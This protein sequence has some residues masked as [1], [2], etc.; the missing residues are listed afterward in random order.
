MNIGTLV[1][2]AV[3]VFAASEVS[4]QP[5]NLSGPFRFVAC[6]IVPEQALLLSPRTAGI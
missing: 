1:L 3:A 4:A 2:A 6:R 5:M